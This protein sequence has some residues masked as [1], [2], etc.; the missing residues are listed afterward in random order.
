MKII[1]D[2]NIKESDLA[3]LSTR[4]G[5]SPNNI[6]PRKL[7]IIGRLIKKASLPESQNQILIERPVSH[8]HRSH[9]SSP[10]KKS[11]GQKHASL[12]Q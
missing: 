5:A 1:Q 11:S 12:L 6:L 9:S 3:G 7:V 8:T 2:T 10:T 4:Y